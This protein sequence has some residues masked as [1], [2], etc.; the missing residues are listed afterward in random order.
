MK[1]FINFLGEGVPA[2]FLHRIRRVTTAAEFHAICAEFL[3]H[4][5]PMSL[6]P[7]DDAAA[8]AVPAAPLA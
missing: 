2:T 7:I 4:G 3:D 5:D 8:A 1:K 6:E